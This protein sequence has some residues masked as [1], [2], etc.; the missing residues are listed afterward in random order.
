MNSPAVEWKVRHKIAV[1]TARGLHYLHKGCQRRI[2]HRDI[3]SS[4]ILLTADFEPQV[5]FWNHSFLF[6][7]F[8]VFIKLLLIQVFFDHFC[9]QISDFGLAKWLPSQWTHHSIAPIE[10][11]FGYFKNSSHKIQNWTI[12]KCDCNG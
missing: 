10:G 8:F 4:N 7:L 12:S 3:K 9:F 2:I 1:G 6:S 11:T 5:C